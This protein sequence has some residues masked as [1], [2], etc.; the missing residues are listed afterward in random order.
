MF[1]IL[2]AYKRVPIQNP[3]MTSRQIKPLLVLTPESRLG[4]AFL[5]DLTS[6]R[7]LQ[8]PTLL[9]APGIHGDA[10]CLMVFAL[11][12]ARAWN[13]PTPGLLVISCSAGNQGL[14]DSPGCPNVWPGLRITKREHHRS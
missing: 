8:H 6:H 10:F 3:P 14:S 7:A 11:A 13:A 9:A 2:N 5:A 4:T 12:V 1:L